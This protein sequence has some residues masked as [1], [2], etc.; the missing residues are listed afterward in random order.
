MSGLVIFLTAAVVYLYVMGGLA[1]VGV[2]M[3]EKKDQDLVA[4]I[5][6]FAAWPIAIAIV[7]VAVAIRMARRK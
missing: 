4:G 1:F 5:F 3:P 2:C 6:L 7:C